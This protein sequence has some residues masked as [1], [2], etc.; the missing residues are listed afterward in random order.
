MNTIETG[1]YIVHLIISLL[2]DHKPM[3]KPD[4]VTFEDIYHMS[5]KHN[6]SVMALIAIDRL[7]VKPDDALYKQWDQH[8]SASIAQGIIQLAERDQLYK[9]LE[10]KQIQYLPLKG[11]LLKEMY[12]KPEFREMSDLDILIRPQSQEEVKEL[13]ESSGYITEN[14]GIKKD[15]SYRKPPFMHVEMHHMLLEDV[16]ISQ[17]NITDSFLLDPFSHAHQINDSGRFELSPEDMY[18]YLMVHNAKH[19]IRKGTGI[20]Q[21]IDFIVYEQTVD[22]DHDYVDK[23]L[24]EIGLGWFKRNSDQ[25]LECWVNGTDIPSE[26]DEMQ[27]TVFSSGSYGSAESKVRIN[28]NNA[29]GN[30]VSSAGYLRYRFFPPYRIMKASYPVLRKKPWLLPAVWIYRISF[31]GVPRVKRHLKELRLFKS[32][33]KY[34]DQE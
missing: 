4:T 23:R 17:M 8:R 26:L 13:M 2:S 9:K 6:V 5:V 32:I 22:I 31:K 25:L 30:K 15:D 18:I 12:P 24:D 21:F 19:Y 10:E 16:I 1:K 11:C 3:E 34:S 29:S 28:M 20:R 27:N 7:T 14:F 33:Q